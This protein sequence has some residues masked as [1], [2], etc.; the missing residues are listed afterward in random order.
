MEFSN[1]SIQYFR[2]KNDK[3]RDND[4]FF[5]STDRLLVLSGMNNVHS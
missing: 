5:F 1:L 4:E 2:D 3:L